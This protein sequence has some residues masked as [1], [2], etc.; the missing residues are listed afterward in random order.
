MRGESVD[1]KSTNNGTN[2]KRAFMLAFLF[3]MELYS[4]EKRDDQSVPPF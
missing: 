1:N 4:E 2:L 3:L